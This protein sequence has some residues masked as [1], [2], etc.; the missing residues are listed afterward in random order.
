MQ[1]TLDKTALRRALLAHRQHLDAEVRREWDRK[2]GE[3]VLAWRRTSGIRR[4]GVYWPIRGEPDL[5]PAF[6]QLTAEGALLSLPIVTQKNAP[7]A[8]AAWAP[9]D[10]MDVDAHGIAVPM[11]DAPRVEPEA[12]LIPCVGFNVKRQRLGYGGGY[13]DRTL[14]G[15]DRPVAIGIAYACCL[16]AFEGGAHDV[17]LDQIITERAFA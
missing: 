6:R 16:C 13:Y 4:L 14:A 7:L 2:I 10:V 17:P 12:L 9:D 3:Y 5:T 8:F 11:I 15:H 1:E